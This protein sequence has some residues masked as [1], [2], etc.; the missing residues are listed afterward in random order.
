MRRI[1]PSRD[2]ASVIG[3]GI[4]FAVMIMLVVLSIRQDR[5]ERALIAAGV[6]ETVTEALYVPPPVA[7][8]SCHGE[9]AASYCTTYYTQSDPYLRT[10]WHCRDQDDAGRVSEFWRS[11]SEGV[12]R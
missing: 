11:S 3:G 5:H 4:A 2:L 7:H 1:S 8:S 9:G 6:C 12:A 10:L